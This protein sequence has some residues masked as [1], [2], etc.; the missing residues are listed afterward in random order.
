MRVE[1]TRALVLVTA[2]TAL[3]RAGA[4]VPDWS[5]GALRA[6][7]HAG[8]GVGGASVATAAAVLF[9]VGS[10]LQQEVAGSSVVGGRLDVRVLL[11]RPA[12]L[13]GQAAT[14]LATA[15]QVTALA[16]APVALVQPVI[17]GGLVV[18]LAGRAVR[19]RR[20][21]G[22]GQVLGAA[23]TTAGLAGFLLAARPARGAPDLVS[24]AWAV[25]ITVSLVLLL[26]LLAPLLGRQAAGAVACGT[27]AGTAMAV[28]AV[29]AAAALKT[30]DSRGLVAALTGLPLWGAVLTALAAELASQQAFARGALSWSL[31]ALTVVDPLA[32]VP[33]AR[34]LLGERLEPGHAAVWLPAAAFAAAGV[35]LLARHE[36]RP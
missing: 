30:W 31:P 22:G 8:V 25:A 2:G 4:R 7:G 33:V 35:V 36:P 16:L 28:A 20:V 9:A 18:A 29:L 17:A 14:L 10:V 32:A 11:A 3:V 13:L 24:Q 34:V 27:A 1:G 23:A 5:V 26:V 12:W 21:P 15:L 6:G 19:D